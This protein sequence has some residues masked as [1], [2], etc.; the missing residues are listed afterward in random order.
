MILSF[1]NDFFAEINYMIQNLLNNQKQFLTVKKILNHTIHF[2]RKIT[3]KAENQ[4]FFYIDDENDVKKFQVIQII[5]FE[6]ELLQQKKKVLLMILIDNFVY[7]IN[8]HI[9]HSILVIN[10]CNHT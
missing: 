1:N 6:Y 8:E 5:K 9:I 2:Y 7:N 10:F 3:V 4:M